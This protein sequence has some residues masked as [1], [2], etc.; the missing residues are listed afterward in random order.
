MSYVKIIF[1][2]IAIWRREQLVRYGCNQRTK[3]F[4]KRIGMKKITGE[5]YK[6]E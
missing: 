3:R 2:S 1:D 6:I 4:E 5:L